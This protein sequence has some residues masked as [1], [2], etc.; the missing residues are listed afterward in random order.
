MVPSTVFVVHGDGSGEVAVEGSLENAD[1]LFVTIEPK[2]GSE[3]P[4]S[5]PLMQA[6]LS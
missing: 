3:S 6:R 2:G 1:A 4:T 5:D